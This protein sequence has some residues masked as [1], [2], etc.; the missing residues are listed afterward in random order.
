MSVPSLHRESSYSV[1]LLPGVTTTCDYSYMYSISG[2]EIEGITITWTT[3]S[4]D[5][6]T[7][8]EKM[9]LY[10]IVFQQMITHSKYNVQC[11]RESWSR[12]DMYTCT[13]VYERG[14]DGQG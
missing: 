4:A 11:V 2:Q 1:L 5:V 6:S 14:G 13:C 10:S 3:E 12:E 8:V 9:Y 7:F